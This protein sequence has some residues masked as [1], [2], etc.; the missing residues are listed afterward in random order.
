MSCIVYYIVHILGQGDYTAPTGPGVGRGGRLRGSVRLPLHAPALR[1]DWE[2]EQEDGQGL[3][4]VPRGK[5]EGGA[6]LSLTYQRTRTST[7]KSSNVFNSYKRSEPV[8]LS[9]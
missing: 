2:R 9:C 5:W 3:L 6:R 8:I 1:R 4:P 7:G